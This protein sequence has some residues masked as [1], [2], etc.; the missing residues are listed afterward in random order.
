MNK[1]VKI[2]INN[3]SSNQLVASDNGVE[4]KSQ[5]ILKK[6]TSKF[7]I[8]FL[9][10]KKN[11]IRGKI[12]QMNTLE[13]QRSR[14]QCRALWNDARYQTV[15]VNSYIVG[16]FIR[17]IFLLYASHKYMYFVSTTKCAHQK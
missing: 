4:K 8:F 16:I 7:K 10:E 12:V 5:E 3:S 13:K 11:L 14:R 9:E 6:K 1:C 15:E 17:K 2:Y